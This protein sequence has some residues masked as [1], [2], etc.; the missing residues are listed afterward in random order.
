MCGERRG[1]ATEARLL[2]DDL[3]PPQVPAPTAMRTEGTGRPTK[4]D[5]RAIAALKR[6]SNDDF[7]D[8]DE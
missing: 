3:T 5:R 4:R 2:Y 6:G 1:P 8:S 7:S